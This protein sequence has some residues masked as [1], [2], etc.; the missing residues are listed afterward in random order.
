MKLLIVDDNAQVRRLICSVLRGVA[1]E[2]INCADG[3]AALAAYDEHRPDWVLMDIEMERMDGLAATAQITGA[4]P[5]A[6]VIIVTNYDS[7]SLREAAWRAGA[8]DYVLKENL[9]T[10]RQRL[11]AVA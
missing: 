6:Q 10:L 11:Q 4:H 2:V 5:E 7:D 1:A 8:C 3:C 9:F